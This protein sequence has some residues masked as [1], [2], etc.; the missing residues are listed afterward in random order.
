MTETLGAGGVI[1]GGGHDG[2]QLREQRLDR[3]ARPRPTACRTPSATRR[4]TTSRAAT[5]T[6]ARDS[7]TDTITETDTAGS[8]LI[9]TLSE[10]LGADGTV[11]GGDESDSLERIHRRHHDRDRP[12]DR[13]GHRFGLGRRR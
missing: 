5:P 13:D 2:E 11:A 4:R 7:G 9:D 10:D 1:V 12:P 3:R 8:T 6:P